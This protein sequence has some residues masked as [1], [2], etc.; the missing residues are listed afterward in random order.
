[1]CLFSFTRKMK[2]DGLLFNYLY[3]WKCLGQHQNQH[4]HPL[5]VLLSRLLNHVYAKIGCYFRLIIH[6]ITNNV[7]ELNLIRSIVRK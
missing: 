2:N 4:N 3:N 1:M 6:Q 5:T 7:A